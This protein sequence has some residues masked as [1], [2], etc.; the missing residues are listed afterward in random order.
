MLRHVIVV[1]LALG[2]GPAF[3]SSPSPVRAQALLPQ[4][5]APNLG[6]VLLDQERFFAASAYGQSVRARIEAATQELETENREI[7]AALTAEEQELTELRATMP[8]TE[9]SVLAEDFDSRVE[10]IRTEQEAK[11]RALE[12][13]LAQARQTFFEEALPVLLEI[14]ASRG[15]AVILDHRSVLLAADSVDITDAAIAA[16]DAA[17]GDGS[18]PSDTPP[19]APEP[20]TGS[21]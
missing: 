12:G 20:A 13:A 3:L 1:L 10:A 2:T 5:A 18:A 21:E 9:F 8:R 15:A 16:V 6:I 4:E 11:A 14:V 7:E 19:P 17:L